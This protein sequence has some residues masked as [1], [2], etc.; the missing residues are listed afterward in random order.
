M[1]AAPQA[2]VTGDMIEIRCD[3]RTVVH[4]KVRESDKMD[5]PEAFPAKKRGR[6]KKEPVNDAE[7]N[8]QPDAG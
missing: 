8:A 4:R 2:K 1:K 7:G 5:W 6:P 3:A